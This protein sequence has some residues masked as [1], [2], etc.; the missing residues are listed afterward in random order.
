MGDQT[1]ADWKDKVMHAC[2]R[3]G[4]SVI[5]GADSPPPHH[6]APQGF[7]VAI[8]VKKPADADR[9]FDALAEGGEITMPLSATFWA[10]RFGMFTD[11]YGVP[12][13][14]NC[15]DPAY[16]ASLQTTAATA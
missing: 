2:L 6:Q 12:W 8:H 11:R 15:E 4:E 13:M 1:P 9:I 3:F 14:I 16:Q 10:K 7:A 5:M